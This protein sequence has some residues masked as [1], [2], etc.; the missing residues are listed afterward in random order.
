MKTLN[1]EQVC[2]AVGIKE[3]ELGKFVKKLK[4]LSKP[5][6][7]DKGKR[8]YTIRDVEKMIVASRKPFKLLTRSGNFQ[9]LVKYYD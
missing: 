5:Q 4:Q 9:E 6:K 1:I 8:V 7:D 2:E 3:S